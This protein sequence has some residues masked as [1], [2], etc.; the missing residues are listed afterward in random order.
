VGASIVLDLPDEISSALD[1]ATRAEG[2]SAS[3]LIGR[4]LKNYL[5]VRRFRRLRA[6]TLEHMRATG[7]GD[8]SDDD[9]FRLVS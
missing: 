9:V 6:E 4:A 5:F 2:L 1:E 7:Q 3:E 8:L